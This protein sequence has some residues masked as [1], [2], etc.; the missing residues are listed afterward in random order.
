MQMVALVLLP[1]GML[2]EISGSLGQ[3]FGVSHLVYMLA[4]GVVLFCLGR[5]LDG[6]GM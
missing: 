1:M 6:Y 5:I 3:L 2:L 4:F